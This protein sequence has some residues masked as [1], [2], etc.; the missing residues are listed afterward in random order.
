MSGIAGGGPPAPGWWIASDGR[1]YP[2]ELHPSVR[3]APP[4]PAI[5]HPG[6]VVP[7]HSIRLALY[8][9]RA[10]GYVVDVVLTLL[11]AWALL[12]L[13]VALVGSTVPGLVLT[14]LFYLWYHA[15]RI[16]TA[17]ATRGM[18]AMHIVVAERATG[19]YPIGFGRAL[20]RLAVT[21]L[22]AC[23]PFGLL[24]DL[25]WPLWDPS[26]QTLHDKAAGTVVLNRS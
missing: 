11:G 26:N 8:G 18:R 25:L 24:V 23:V 1:W 10:I 3:Q 17:G 15:W 22:I 2:P 9:S 7:P 13:S 6:T 4:L 12:L 19:R 14:A 5:G 21:L 20:A 16:A